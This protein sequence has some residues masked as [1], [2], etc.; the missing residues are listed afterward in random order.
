MIV[1]PV[2]RSVVYHPKPDPH[3]DWC[4][5]GKLEARVAELE[6]QGQADRLRLNMAM[7]LLR[8][9]DDRTVGQIVMR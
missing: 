2:C 7:R 3:F 8:E 9:L 4:P 1:C 6:K 5:M